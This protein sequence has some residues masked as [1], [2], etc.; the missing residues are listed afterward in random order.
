VFKIGVS[1][2]K[3][4]SKLQSFAKQEEN[5]LFFKSD[6]THHRFTAAPVH[7]IEEDD[8]FDAYMKEIEKDAVVQ[9]ELKPQ[10]MEDFGEEEEEE[11]A[12]KDNVVTFEDLMEVDEDR[13]ATSDVNEEEFHQQFMRELKKREMMEK[14]KQENNQVLFNDEDDKFIMD[15]EKVEEEADSFLEKEKRKA[16]KRDLKFVNHDDIFYDKINKNLY[17]ETKEIAKM[18]DKEVAEF[19]KTN[20]DIKVRGLK[21]PKPI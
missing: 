18:T 3:K 15:F 14:L 1:N 20:G 4:V 12:K 16:E 5:P 11:P 17:I 10:M 2:G 9:E 6:L 21:C 13:Q 19:R 8:P 7:Q